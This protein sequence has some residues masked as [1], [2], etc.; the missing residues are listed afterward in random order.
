MYRQYDSIVLCLGAT[1]P[2]DIAIPG[3]Q[4]DGIYQA[5]AFLD[6]WQKKQS[7]PNKLG[8]PAFT[9]K[10]KD[11][12]ILGENIEFHVLLFLEIEIKSI[13]TL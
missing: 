12:I 4:L 2:R 10:D 8:N 6:T 3:R 5:V 11:V 9:A 13:T 1:S 7:M